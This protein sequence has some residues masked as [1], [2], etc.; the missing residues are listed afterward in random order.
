MYHM[1]HFRHNPLKFYFF[2]SCLS[3]RL[4]IGLLL[5]SSFCSTALHSF[6]ACFDTQAGGSGTFVQ[7]LLVC[8]LGFLP[9]IW[10]KHIA[11][12]AWGQRWV[13][14]FILKALEERKYVKHF[15]L[16][17]FFLVVIWHI[18]WNLNCAYLSLLVSWSFCFESTGCTFICSE[19]KSDH[20][21]QLAIQSAALSTSTPVHCPLDQNGGQYFIFDDKDTPVHPRHN[22][23]CV[24]YN[25]LV[26]LFDLK[27]S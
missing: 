23:V 5:S 18:F 27:C 25:K 16:W 9:I 10:P 22:E 8:L 4:I 2:L 12:S 11:C 24:V 17:G 1:M 15:L 20:V 3:G 26:S 7:L 13:N 14:V 6:K 19:C 21:V